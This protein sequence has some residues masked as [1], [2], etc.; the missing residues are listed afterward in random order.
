MRNKKGF[1]LV[2]LL[3][4]IVILGI[5]AAVAILSI[6]NILDNARK[7]T[8]VANANAA[9]GAFRTEY[10]MN[11]GTNEDFVKVGTTT[12]MTVT[13]INDLLEKKLVNSPY[14]ETYDAA[15]SYVKVVDG[16]YSIC[17]QETGEGTAARNVI[18][19]TAESALTRDSVTVVTASSCTLPTE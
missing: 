8:Y 12:Y 9:I 17:I 7:D 3:A 14:G 6:S 15:N 16:V 11:A 18:V 5:L 13:N 1:T 10:M 19:E 4:V 2:E